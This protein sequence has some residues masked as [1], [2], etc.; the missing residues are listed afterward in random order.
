[1]KRFLLLLLILKIGY[2]SFAQVEMKANNYSPIKRLSLKQS[3]ELIMQY[4]GVL[5][6]SFKEEYLNEAF[7]LDNGQA[8]LLFET[9][10]FLYS[11][12]AAI[13]NWISSLN[14]K[15]RQHGASHILEGRLLYGK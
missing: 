5:D 3:K 4:K 12:L 9:H 6:T 11:S 1:M 14:E 7:V 8:V 2:S 15:Q 10:G 13:K